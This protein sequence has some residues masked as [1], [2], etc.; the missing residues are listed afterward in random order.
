[1]PTGKSVCLVSNTRSACVS[2]HSDFLQD[3][4]SLD[5]TPV[6]TSF[7]VPMQTFAM[8]TQTLYKGTVSL[9][10][11]K[12]PGRGADHL[13]PT[14]VAIWLEPYIR[15]PTVS[16]YVYR[17]VTKRAINIRCTRFISFGIVNKLHAWKSELESQ[18]RQDT[19]LF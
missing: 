8:P 5:W 1:M 16:A 12:R 3:W 7:S 6:E 11:L 18:Q 2:R 15:L 17:G 14:E 4:R 9:P 19:F 13:P 10:G